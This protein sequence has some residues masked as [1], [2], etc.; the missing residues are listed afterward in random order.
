MSANRRIIT[1][2]LVLVLLVAG[3]LAAEEHAP[4][5]RRRKPE[6]NAPRHAHRRARQHSHLPQRG[7]SPAH[8]PLQIWHQLT[9]TSF[10]DLEEGKTQTGWLLADILEL[11][12]PP[13]NAFTPKA[14]SSCA[15][16]IAKK[17]YCLPVD[18]VMDRENMVLCLIFPDGG[19]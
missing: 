8:L 3:I 15:A 18:E 14:K 7:I 12:L 17:K 2:L 6:P 10:Q 1:G 5:A 19:R 9:E 4:A 16:I 13:W 11:Y